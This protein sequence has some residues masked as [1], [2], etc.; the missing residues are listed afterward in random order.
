MTHTPDRNRYEQLFATF[1]RLVLREDPKLDEIELREQP[2]SI[3]SAGEPEFADV[4]TPKG[5]CERADEI[6]TTDDSTERCEQLGGLSAMITELD[7]LNH[8]KDFLVRTIAE[9]NKLFAGTDSEFTRGN[10]TIMLGVL[11]RELAT[12]RT[13]MEEIRTHVLTTLRKL[14]I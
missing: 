4:T 8:R 5:L 6:L 7:T 12:L 2:I 1:R 9:S 3:N 11:K 14:Y 10:I 13:S